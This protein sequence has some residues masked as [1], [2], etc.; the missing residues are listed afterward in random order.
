MLST[1]GF[2]WKAHKRAAGQLTGLAL[3][4]DRRQSATWCRNQYLLLKVMRDN[5]PRTAARLSEESGLS[6]QRTYS[7]LRDL[8]ATNRLTKDGSTYCLP[9]FS[10]AAKESL[11]RTKLRWNITRNNII[12]LPGGVRAELEVPE[13][14]YE[15]SSSLPDYERKILQVKATLKLQEKILDLLMDRM[16]PNQR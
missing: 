4:R 12:M 9:D 5:K 16:K 13:L 8:V 15:K 2:S 7:H 10:D 3:T 14:E 6:R 11:E 1:R